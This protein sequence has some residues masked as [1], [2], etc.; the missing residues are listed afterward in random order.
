L[1]IE[2]IKQI[3]EKNNNK[4]KEKEIENEEYE[5]RML[6]ELINKYPDFEFEKQTGFIKRGKNV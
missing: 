6:V 5:K 2:K 3:K 1:A 4:E